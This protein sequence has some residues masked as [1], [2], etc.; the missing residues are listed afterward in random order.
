MSE[1][2]ENEK[3]EETNSA[4][5]DPEVVKRLIEESPPLV[6]Q[7]IEAAERS[8]H[9][10]IEAAKVMHGR[11]FWLAMA[12]VLTGAAASIISLFQGNGGIAE[13]IIIPLISFVGGLG[14]GGKLK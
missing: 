7:A 3:H 10:G 12:V 8:S 5:N 6:K 14:L 4:W 13:K 1:I 2:T 11:M 9:A